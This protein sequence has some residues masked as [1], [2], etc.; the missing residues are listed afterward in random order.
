[1]KVF[2]RA[3]IALAISVATVGAVVVGP[4]TPASAGV[5]TEA[6]RLAQ[7]PGNC[8]SVIQFYGPVD[9]GIA[10]AFILVGNG[11]GSVWALA[12][13]AVESAGYVAMIPGSCV[14]L[15]TWWGVPAGVV[16]CGF[17]AAGLTA[18]AVYNLVL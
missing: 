10:C 8:V 17:S 5:V 6:G 11:A 9:G 14:S 4:A 1:M 12:G 18:G 2:K 13:D 7:Q 15:V 3:A 16:L